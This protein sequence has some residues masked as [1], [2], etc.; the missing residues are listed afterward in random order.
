M[1]YRA[2]CDNGQSGIWKGLA[3]CLRQAAQNISR[4]FC[5]PACHLL[6][7]LIAGMITTTL[8]CPMS[9]RGQTTADILGTVTDPTGAVVVNA[10]VTLTNVATSVK[11]QTKTSSSGDYLFTLLLNG[12]YTI[13]VEAQG[14]KSFSMPAVELSAGARQRVDVH[15]AIGQSAETVTVT[16]APPAIQTDSSS[17][18]ST[19]T[20]QPVEDLPLNGRNFINL[21][22]IAVGVNNGPGN[23]V[24]SGA[25]PS[26]R[27]QTSAFSANSLDPS[28]NNLMVD[29]MDNNERLIATIGVRPSI[30]SIAEVQI[31]TGDYS[32]DV[33]RS[34]GGAVNVITKGGSNELHGAAYEFLRNDI[35]DAKDVLASTGKKPKLRQNQFGGSFGGPIRKERAFFF[36]DYEGLRTIVG[37]SGEE[38]VPTL[39]EEQHIG[40]FSDVGGPVISSSEFDTAGVNYFKLYPAPNLDNTTPGGINYSNT[41]TKTQYQHVADGRVDYLFK[42]GDPLFG[43]YTFNLTNT[44]TPSLFPL[45]SVAGETGI[46]PGG[47][48]SFAS[49]LFS[50]GV[51]AAKTSNFLLTYSHPFTQNV[52]MELKAGYTRIMLTT[53]QATYGRDLGVAFG[54]PGSNYNSLTSGLPF[55]LEVGSSYGWFGGTP[56]LPLE[57]L[58]NTFQYAGSLTY[59]RGRHTVKAGGTII[60]RQLEN[61]QNEWG[62]MMVNASFAGPYAGQYGNQPYNALINM[63]TGNVLLRQRDV[64]LAP[65]YFRSWE[66]G[67]YVQD[68]WHAL[69]WLTLNLGVRWDTITPYTE[70]HNKISNFD[71]SATNA[72][73]GKGAIRIAGQNGFSNTAGIKTDHAD[74][75]PRIGFEAAIRPTTVLRGGIGFDY[76]PTTYQQLAALTNPPFVTSFVDHNK[77]STAFPSPTAASADY[78]TGAINSA[79]ALNYRNAVV[80]Q[81]NLTLQ[82]D[83]SGNVV[84]ASY[85]GVLGRH[86]SRAYNLDQAPPNALGNTLAAQELRPFFSLYCGVDS[87]GAPE[88]LAE[89]APGGANSQAS[90]ANGVNSISYVDSEGILSF[91]ALEA[92]FERRPRKG[93]GWNVNYTWQHAIDDISMGVNGSAAPSVPSEISKLDRGNSGLEIVSHI[94]G[95]IDYELPFA[96]KSKGLTKTL[97]QGWQA[98]TIVVWQTGAPFTVANGSDVSNTDPGNG[99]SDLPNQIASGK[100]SNPSPAHWFDTSAFVAQAAGTLGNER[101][102]Q[103]F[104]PHFRHWDVSAFK[105][106]KTTERLTAQFRAEFFNVTNTPNW[107]LPDATLGDPNIGVISTTAGYET[108]RQVQFALKLMF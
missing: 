52:I 31:L 101:P 4:P 72:Y 46:S 16:S 66:P 59:V 73:G 62:A 51:S 8:F 12:T 92:S 44:N 39:Y 37:E 3:T 71:P 10:Q 104:G 40:D 13:N 55:L 60:R 65:E 24:N 11:Q 45:A 57:F 50:P 9:S 78:P 88:T 22:Q 64:Q 80:E 23:A 18:G 42:N 48:S 84:T 5:R 33:S 54:I 97:L 68:N 1:S 19:L 107:G 94:A 7:F 76:Y 98:N 34:G 29:G 38:A 56:N 93:I 26:D 36:G 82:Q 103:L 81:M 75:S 21:V 58:D 67:I 61:Q 91:N 41:E 105:N 100:I 99:K 20:S 43:R 49:D 30:D 87:S 108:P 25:Q 83:F 85:V 47:T 28:A 79:I 27:R 106:F 35:F 90:G 96:I 17:I 2:K 15:L 70:I 53:Q 89:C 74:F 69:N 95:S 6:A 14:F 102:N 86:M 77:I 32:A 63:I